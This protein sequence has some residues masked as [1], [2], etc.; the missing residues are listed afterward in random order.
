[1]RRKNL[2]AALLCTFAMA[3]A[4][5]APVTVMAEETETVTEAAVDAEEADTEA[6]EDEAD[7]EAADEEDT[8][9][10]VEETEAIPPRPEYTALDYVTLGEYKGLKVAD[11]PVEV[12]DDQINE[13]VRQNIQFADA[14]EKVTEGTVEDGDTANIDYEGKLD[15]EAFDGGT[16][17]GYDLVIGSH[18]FIDGF[19]DGLIGVTVGE[20]VDL[21]LTFP[22][23]YGNADLAGKE[24]VFT[25]TVNEIKRM[26]ELTDELASTI[27]DGEYTDAAGYRDSIRADLEEQAQAQRDMMLKSD[28]LTQVASGSEVK[29]YPQEMVDYGV[30]NMDT[31]YR[32]MAEQYAMEFEEFLSSFLG[33][34]EED[35]SEQVVLA[36]QQNLQQE[37]YLKAIAETEGIEVTDEDLAEAAKEFGFETTE[38]FIAAYGEDVVRISVLQDKTLDFLLENAV[39]TEAEA[40]TEAPAEEAET[41]VSAA[42]AETEVSEAETEAPAA[43]AE[44]ETEQ[45]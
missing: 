36:T 16:A 9:E 13:V 38:E 15:G 7:T 34:T 32:G 12:T 8:T 19:E 22:E 37:M 10:A 27:S 25:V 23:N 14:L 2:M 17:K 42:E 29:E 41:E 35:F 21:P 5:V 40:E 31:Y 24:V 6:A 43:E 4:S 26:P 33:M 44:T 30:A 1:M 11:Q 3:A 39:I 18:S 45:D 28:L 20:T